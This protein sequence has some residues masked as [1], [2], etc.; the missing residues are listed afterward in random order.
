MSNL[1]GSAILMVLGV[2]LWVAVQ[3]MQAPQGRSP[4][5]PR[6]VRT[7]SLSDS[8][9]VTLDLERTGNQLRIRGVFGGTPPAPGS[10]TYRLR[11]R[12]EGAAGTTRT[13]QSGSF[14]PVPG[15]TD[16]LSTVTVNV[17]AEDRLTV[18]LV[19]EQ[20]GEQV[21]TARVDRIVSSTNDAEFLNPRR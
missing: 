14:T 21:G 13:Q 16:T 3:V 5:S 10:L 18:R 15:T 17:A 19:V 2:G 11:V 6:P 12:R 9:D 1:L 7:A 4:R 8:T 20:H